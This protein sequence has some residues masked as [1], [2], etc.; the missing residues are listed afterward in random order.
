VSGFAASAKKGFKHYLEAEDPDILIVTETKLQQAPADPSLMT[1]FPHQ[2]WSN[3]AT[4]GY[5]GTAILSKQAPLSITNTIPGH[6]NPTSVKGRIV[7]LEFEK[8]YLV[9]TYVVNAGQGLKTLEE[10]KIWN[11]H[12][13]EYL[14]DLD[15]TKPVIW[16]GDFN[17]AP[18]EIDL[19]HPKPNWNK[20]PGYTEVETTAFKNFLEPPE[21]SEANKFIDV[22][23]NLHPEERAYTY[24]SY[25]FN[26]RAKGIGWRLDGFVLSERLLER[27]KLC[28]IRDEIYGA[29]DHCPVVLEIG[30]IL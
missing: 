16:A 11:T 8:C 30:G 23:R 14:R 5:A 22:W 18:T 17:V 9:G 2:Y 28:E 10:K 13:F 12:F 26:C 15:K 7:T 27:V 20:T 24:F 6:P 19:A 21:N 25:R 4:K 3:S 29:S 1:R